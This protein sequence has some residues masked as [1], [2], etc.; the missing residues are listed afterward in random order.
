MAGEGTA[1][2]AVRPLL[3]PLCREVVVTGAVPSAMACKMAVNLYLI[4]SF[5]ALAEAAALAKAQDLSS[6]IFERVI[7]GD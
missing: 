6:A 1:L 5:A 3:Q 2:K 4:A 7:G